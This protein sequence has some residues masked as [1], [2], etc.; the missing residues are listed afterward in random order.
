MKEW[1]AVTIVLIAFSM[2]IAAAMYNG[3][4]NE[5]VPIENE[6]VYYEAVSYF[7]MG[8]YGN[9]AVLSLLTAALI[10]GRHYHILSS[11]LTFFG[12]LTINGIYDEIFAKDPSVA[13]N[14][15][16]MWALAAFLLAVLDFFDLNL[17][18]LCKTIS[19]N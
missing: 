17:S 7:V 6:E 2:S 18:K 15:E 5:N 10:K 9:I 4:V 1:K 8:V 14:G 3:W 13:S 11:V 16:Y 19:K 12:Y